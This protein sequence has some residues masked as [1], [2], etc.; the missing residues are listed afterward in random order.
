MVSP[1][2]SEEDLLS[3]ETVS[4]EQQLHE[5]IQQDYEDLYPPTG[6]TVKKRGF[7]GQFRYL[8]W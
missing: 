4:S 3:E 8:S 2:Y 7:L 6:E 5:E 1:N